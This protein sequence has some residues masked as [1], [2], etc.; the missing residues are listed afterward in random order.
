MA[1][2]TVEL[3]KTTLTKML[4][5]EKEGEKEILKVNPYEERNVQIEML[6]HS[7]FR[8][9]GLEP[10]EEFTDITGTDDLI[11]EV[12]AEDIALKT[13]GWSHWLGEE[14]EWLWYNGLPMGK[15]ISS[16]RGNS[17]GAKMSLSNGR[18]YYANN[19]TKGQ[20]EENVASRPE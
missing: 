5:D 4:S 17:Y 16:A 19:D 1:M 6:I 9:C 2:N 3:K 20:W 11:L 10:D 14:E 18:K 8:C 13:E 7:F 15:M 12:E